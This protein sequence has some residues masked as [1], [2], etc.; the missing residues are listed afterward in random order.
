MPGL[1]PI[2][3]MTVE[4]FK[5]PTIFFRKSRDFFARLELVPHQRT[6]GAKQVVGRTSKT[7]Q[8]DIRRLMITS[9]MSVIR[10]ASRKGAVP[11]SWLRRAWRRRWRTSRHPTIGRPP[12]AR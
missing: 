12:R 4:T 8:R 1:G 6:N 5:P 7:G 10:W 11:G 3:A 2:A 9:T